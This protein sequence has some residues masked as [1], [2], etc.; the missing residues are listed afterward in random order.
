M[1]TKTQVISLRNVD[2]GEN[3]F[4]EALKRSINNRFRR[5]LV[6]TENMSDNST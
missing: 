2:A 5:K 6:V 3:I 1:S 4:V